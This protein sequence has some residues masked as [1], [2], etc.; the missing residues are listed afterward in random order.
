MS[1]LLFDASLLILLGI[2]A[3][4]SLSDFIVLASSTR[5]DP[6]PTEPRQGTPPRLLVLIPAHNEQRLVGRA[7]KSLLEAHYPSDRRR[8]VVI[9]DNCEDETAREATDAGA[10]CLVRIEPGMPGKPQALAWATDRALTW[11]DWEAIVVVDA[12]SIVEPEF[13][14]AIGATPGLQHV[15]C[16]ARNGVENDDETWLTVLG[17]LLVRARY[18]VLFECKSRRGLNCPTA[19]NGTGIGRGLLQ[20]GWQ[21]F[22][23]TEGWELY[24]R[25]TLDG[26]RSIY[27][28]RA[29]IASQE[30]RS[31]SQSA[32]QKRRWTAGRWHVLTRFG[33]RIATARQLSVL[34]RLDTLCELANP[35]P[36]T[37]VGSM[38]IVLFVAL[39]TV[40]PPALLGAAVPVTVGVAP[41][42]VAYGLALYQH[43]RPMSAIKALARLPV[44]AIWRLP[45]G[46]RSMLVQ[47]SDAWKATK[48]H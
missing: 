2:L 7:V 39:V 16:Q 12:D 40:D 23:L 14:Q 19:G 22:S 13:L 3:F 33:W 25:M 45:V 6:R 11:D 8:V 47:R 30:P 37:H 41:Y 5:R 17:D 21:A 27:V 31:I 48:R 35:G 10:E 26:H 20:S 18:D 46:L 44:Y 32:T 29:R 1:H 4:P 36:V 24:A 28:K 43:P 42:L 9:A 15:I 34:Q 38:A